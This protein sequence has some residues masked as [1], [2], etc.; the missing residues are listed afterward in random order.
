MKTLCTGAPAC[1]S[2]G[3]PG[4]SRVFGGGTIRKGIL[5][6]TGR[7]R[8]QGVGRSH[9]TEE[10]GEQSR[11][12]HAPH[13]ARGSGVRGGKGI[14]QGKRHS[15][16]TRAGRRVGE[17]WH[18]IPSRITSANGSSVNAH[19]EVFDYPSGIERLARE[20]IRYV[21]W[22]LRRR[23]HSINGTAPASNIASVPGSGTTFRRM[24]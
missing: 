2:P 14:D 23:F 1:G 22:C 16:L 13:G 5:P 3:D 6:H 15:N 18:G 20:S 10:A 21:K 9:S 19:V 8:F 7:A 24:L 12:D 11:P 17:A 4:R